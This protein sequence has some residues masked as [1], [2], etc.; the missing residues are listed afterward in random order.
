MIQMQHTK[1]MIVSVKQELVIL[2]RS[3]EIRD[4]IFVGLLIT[5]AESTKIDELVVVFLLIVSSL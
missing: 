2:N 1:Y 4:W 3:K 5:P